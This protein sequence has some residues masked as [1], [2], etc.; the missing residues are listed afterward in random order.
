MAMTHPLSNPS[1][2][3]QIWGMRLLTVHLVTLAIFTASNSGLIDSST[4]RRA[5]RAQGTS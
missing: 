5:K 2:P 4:L 3:F 1:F